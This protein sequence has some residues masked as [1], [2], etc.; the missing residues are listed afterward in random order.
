MKGIFAVLEV[1]LLAVCESTEK[2]P[3]GFDS[4]DFG[5]KAVTSLRVSF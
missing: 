1:M 2:A 5:A 3:T 4:T